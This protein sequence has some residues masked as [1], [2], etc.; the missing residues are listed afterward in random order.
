MVLPCPGV[1][2]WTAPSQ[3]LETRS[4][5]VSAT[6]RASAQLVARRDLR[7]HLCRRHRA[8]VEEHGGLIAQRALP[9]DRDEDAPLVVRPRGVRGGGAH[10]VVPEEG[11]ARLGIVGGL[12]EVG[13]GGDPHVEAPRETAGHV[14]APQPKNKRM[15]PGPVKC[16]MSKSRP[17]PS[18]PARTRV[19]ITMQSPPPGDVPL[20]LGIWFAP[21]SRIHAPTP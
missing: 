15:S 13:V 10:R 1:A 3:K 6:R 4:T 19:N 5:R 2:A 7:L 21:G 8:A 17:A 14:G 12:P 18:S 11:P 9:V 16:A 20:A